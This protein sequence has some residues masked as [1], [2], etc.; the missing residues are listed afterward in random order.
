MSEQPKPRET[1]YTNGS[2]V[3]EDEQG[4]FVNA[5]IETE[6]WNSYLRKY[7]KSGTRTEKV[8]MDALGLLKVASQKIFIIKKVSSNQTLSDEEVAFECTLE[9]S[10]PDEAR[11]KPFFWRI[12]KRSGEVFAVDMSSG[13][14]SSAGVNSEFCKRKNVKVCPPDTRISKNAAV[15]M[16]NP[17]DNTLERKLP[18]VM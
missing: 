10:Y 2:V 4:Y 5:T 14:C 17:T 13:V 8:R 1:K 6:T 16:L 7:E 9:W 12:S 11:Y 15:F 18:D 3:Y